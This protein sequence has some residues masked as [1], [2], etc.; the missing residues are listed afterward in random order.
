MGAVVFHITMLTARLCSL[1]VLETIHPER[2]VIRPFDAVSMPKSMGVG[3]PCQTSPLHM[4][5]ANINE[6]SRYQSDKQSLILMAR[7]TATNGQG[8]KYREWY[9]TPLMGS[10]LDPGGIPSRSVTPPPPVS[11]PYPAPGYYPLPWPYPYPGHC[12]VP[13][14][15]PYP[16]YAFPAGPIPTFTSTPPGSETGGP[17]AGGHLPWPNMVYNVCFFS[18]VIHRWDVS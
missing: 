3:S 2:R 16:G 17:A 5:P 4:R 10:P 1:C 15:G 11:A 7:S 13:Y 18:F 12:Q 14:C 8:E 9:D 6:V